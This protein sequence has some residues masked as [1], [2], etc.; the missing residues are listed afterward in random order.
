MRRPNIT[1]KPDGTILVERF[2]PPRRVEHLLVIVTFTILVATGLPQ[3]F[4]HAGWAPWILGVL[5]GLDTA[6]SVHR[7]TGWVLVGQAAIHLSALLIG[8]LTKKMR[9]TLLPVPQDL[10]DAWHNLG[11][12]LGYRECPA[13][14]PKFDY[15]QKFEYF[16]MLLGTGV[17]LVTGLVLMYPVATTSLLPGEVIP[18]ARVAHSSEAVLA[19][20]VLLVW[21]LYSSHLSP[22]VFPVDR[23][24]FTGY[25]TLD[26]LKHHHAREYRRLFPDGPPTDS[27]PD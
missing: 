20:L 16:G 13:E 7:V 10:R 2:S 15:R 11:Y 27:A 8:V 12:Y 24:I 1:S 22:E 21:H 9:L 3:K 4:H 26:E 25:L 18:A 19:L 6:R 23:S 17:M 5:G 14:L